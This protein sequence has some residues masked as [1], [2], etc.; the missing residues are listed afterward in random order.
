MPDGEEDLVIG[1]G[2]GIVANI[3]RFVH[4]VKWVIFWRGRYGED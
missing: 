2:K 1:D 4:S 3:T